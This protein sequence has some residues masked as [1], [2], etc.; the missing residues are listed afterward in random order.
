MFAP[1]YHDIPLFKGLGREEINE[2]LHKFHGLIKH[3]PKSDY[4]YLAGDCIEN[5]CVVMEGTVQMIKEDIW[6]EKSIIANLSAGDV[7]AE[8]YL[9]KLL[10]LIHI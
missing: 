9:G 8:N 3:F 1:N 4:I 10:S 5:L 7:F 2:V 6:G